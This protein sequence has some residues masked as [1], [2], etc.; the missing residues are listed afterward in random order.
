LRGYGIRVGS[1]LLLSHPSSL[2]HD[3]GP[4]PERAD[5]LRAIEAALDAR[6]WLHWERRDSP[7]A[8]LEQLHALHPPAYVDAIRE[9]C[10][11]GGGAL[12][13]DTVA[14]SG[15][16]VAAL[17]A[18]GGGAAAVDAVLGG[19]AP[20]AFSVH[21]PP[22]HHAEA[23]RAM[24]FCLFNNVAVA[25]RHA[26]DAHGL[27]RVLVL[28]WDVHHGNG[29][30]DLFHESPQV[31]FVSIHES[32]LYPGSG[33]AADT[34]SGAGEGFTVNLPVPH[35]S[36]DETFVSLVAHVVAPLA[37]AFEAQLVLVSAGYDAH[38][39]DPL[40]GCDV[41][42]AGYAAMAAIVRAMGVP[43]V[44][45]LEGGYDLGAV[46]RGVVVT[47]DALGSGDPPTLADVPEHE[48]AAR[49]RERLGAGA[50]PALA[51]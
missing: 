31:L 14:S 22:G 15:S 43:V 37:R 35:G 38:T 51:G 34:G 33:P 28:D 26:I 27:E 40:A 13:L 9:F 47:M 16:W 19:E 48:L 17:H 32:P 39:D 4:H 12:D 41:T 25:A 46:S 1:P 2:D 6:E 50:W 36:G 44:V 45:T 29:T 21:R 11:R 7:E 10:A 23:A 20:A 18:A 5:R 24:G 8:T 3:T 30:N 49:A 42:D